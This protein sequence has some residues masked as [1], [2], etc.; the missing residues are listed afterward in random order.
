MGDDAV[1]V[2]DG[3]VMTLDTDTKQVAAVA[4]PTDEPGPALKVAR[5]HARKLLKETA[6]E[7][8]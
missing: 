8:H 6:R 5:N 1:L 7:F 4:S 2:E 3:G